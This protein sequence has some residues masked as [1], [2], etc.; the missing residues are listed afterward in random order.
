MEAS[1]ERC[2]EFLTFFLEKIVSTRAIVS[3]QS[4]NSY[5]LIPC[6]PMFDHF[7]PVL[8]T[9]LEQLISSSKPSGLPAE[10][11]PPRFLS[12]WYHHIKHAV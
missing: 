7:E 10:I 11:I 4:Y 12:R 1:K 3:P 5:I 6:V 8:L 2:D 9:M